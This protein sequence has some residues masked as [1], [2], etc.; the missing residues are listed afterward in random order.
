MVEARL[1]LS[2]APFDALGGDVGR[3]VGV[4]LLVELGGAQVPGDDHLEGKRASRVP[5]VGTFRGRQRDG[6]GLEVRRVCGGQRPLGEAHVASA[7]R[8]HAAVEPRLGGDPVRCVPPVASFGE[9]AVRASRPVRAPAG[10]QDVP[11]TAGGELRA[12]GRGEVDP[13]VRRAFQ[14]GGGVVDAHGVVDVGQQHRPIRHCDLDVPLDLDFVSA[15]PHDDSLRVRT[16]RCRRRREVM[17][18]LVGLEPAV[19][20]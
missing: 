19:H 18:S 4:G 3:G 14:D 7:E 11:V 12:H 8:A 2:H 16:S 15:L 17:S 6:H 10:L 20:D 1:Q 5:R 13:A 9:V